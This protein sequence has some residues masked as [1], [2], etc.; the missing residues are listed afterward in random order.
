MLLCNAVIIYGSV[1]KISLAFLRV[2][3][4]WYFEADPGTSRELAKRFQMVLG[5]PMLRPKGLRI[6]MLRGR[7]RPLTLALAYVLY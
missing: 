4:P 6:N 5:T 3:D 2:G 7:A 1:I